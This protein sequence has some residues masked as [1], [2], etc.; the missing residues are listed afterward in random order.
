MKIKKQIEIIQAL[1]KDA[2]QLPENCID[3]QDDSIY[4]GKELVKYLSSTERGKD[5]P[6]INEGK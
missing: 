2:E 6:I 5:A 3:G 1:I 4:E